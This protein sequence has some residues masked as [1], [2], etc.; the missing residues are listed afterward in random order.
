VYYL[1]SLVTKSSNVRA[2]R[3]PANEAIVDAKKVYALSSYLVHHLAADIVAK[4]LFSRHDI[5]SCVDRRL[6]NLSVAG[7]VNI[8]HA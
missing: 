4:Q 5:P 6:S 7:E 8:R 2:C 3:T 1:A